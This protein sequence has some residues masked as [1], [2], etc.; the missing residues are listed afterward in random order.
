MK[1]FYTLIFALLLSS[2]HAADRYL[3]CKVVGISDGDT[4]TCLLNKSKLKVRLVHI[5]APEQPQPYGNSAKQAL[6]K[7]VFRKKVTIVV[8][9]HDHYQRILAE[10]YLHNGQNVNLKLVEMGMAWAYQSAKP[11]YEQAQQ[12]AKTARVGLWQDS[13]PVPPSEW[14]KQ[15]V[16]QQAVKN[17]KNFANLPKAINC[18]KKLKCNQ[19]NNYELA[20]RYFQQCGWKALD[21]NND[22]I[23]CNTL[24]W[25]SKRKH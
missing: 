3:Q 16:P 1:F 2:A 9:G 19:I 12:R 5:D 25:K 4:L 13:S 15:N 24:Y 21:G 20:K 18:H 22:G 7:L 11:Q 14:R 8:K 23:P 6:L 10:V 17:R